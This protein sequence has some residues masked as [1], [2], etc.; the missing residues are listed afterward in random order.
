MTY[1]PTNWKNSPSKDTPI[2]SANLMKIEEEL[3]YLTKQTVYNIDFNNGIGSGVLFRIG[4][5]CQ[6]TATIMLSG[7]FQDTEI[8]TLPDGFKGVMDTV[9]AICV[10]EGTTSVNGFIR[11]GYATNKI[12]LTTDSTDS[13]IVKFSS[14]YLTTDPHML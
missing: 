11:Y 13:I 2:N 5:T 1:S 7:A 6:L 3:V 9:R 4:N 10:T 8:G 12:F 14:T